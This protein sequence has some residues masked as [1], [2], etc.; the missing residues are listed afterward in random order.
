MVVCLVRDRTTGSHRRLLAVV[1]VACVALMSTI[2]VAS[3]SGASYHALEWGLYRGQTP[4]QVGELFDV[5]AVSADP[6]VDQ[7]M[8]PVESPLGLALLDNGTV[9]YWTRDDLF[10]KEATGLVG[11]TAVAAGGYD[12]AL[13][14]NGTVMEVG[15]TVT[16]TGES[17][18]PVPVS[19]IT[20]AT[21]IASG[22][23]NGAALLS[24]GTVRTWGTDA[25]GALGDGGGEGTEVPVEVCGVGTEG[26]CPHGPYLSGVKAIASGPFSGL[27][28]LS[29]GTVVTWGDSNPT[30]VPVSGLSDVQAI[31]TADTHFDALIA[32]GTVQ[33]WSTSYFGGGPGPLATISGLGGVTAISSGLGFN[34]ALLGDGTV[35][36]WGGKVGNRRQPQPGAVPV[37]VRDV[38]GAVGI[39]AGSN[40]ALAFGTPS[41]PTVKKLSPR[42]G[43]VAGGT[44]VTIT[45][46]SL[47]GAEVAFG[48]TPAEI[49][50]DSSKSITVVSPSA[51]AGRVDVTVS[52]PGGTSPIS[53]R[54]RFTYE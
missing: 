12:L 49:T 28:L 6:S 23:T 42:T 24:D 40:S 50:S 54:D 35:M 27:A 2:G 48:S 8:Y 22:E 19:G 10:P 45:G 43:P 52:T 9:M 3:A 13:L 17:S 16:E 25:Y 30:P 4:V 41:T 38:T 11:V 53:R 34:L 47:S 32:D 33:E 29:D 5:T 1:M 39:S 31:S 14:S 26:P 36:T 37:P 7:E 18:P 20:D 51:T 44:T 21:A 15:G 46:T